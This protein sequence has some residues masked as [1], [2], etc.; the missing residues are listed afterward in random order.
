MA[1]LDDEKL[2][3]MLSG[4]LKDSLASQCGRSERHFRRYLNEGMRSVWRQRTW[5]LGA[6]VTGM[7]ASVA[8]LW[9]APML[10]GTAPAAVPQI[11][12]AG[13]KSQPD[14]NVTTVVPAVERVVQSHTTDEGVM[15]FGNDTPIRV[16]RRQQ[17]EQTRWLDAQQKMQTKQSVPEDELLFIKMPT[18]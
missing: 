17:L 3:A 11:V 1:E 9:A 8:I 10:R 18:Y 4:F 6:F 15:L 7:A 12:D 5:L 16:L 2:D 13:T 14:V